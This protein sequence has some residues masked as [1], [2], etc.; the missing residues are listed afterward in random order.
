MEGDETEELQAALDW[1]NEK[2]NT[3]L[4]A[5][6]SKYPNESRYETALRYI[7]ERESTKTKGASGTRAN[8][9]FN[10]E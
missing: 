2:M 1:L 6:E 4:L 3:L 5:V 7:K 10:A 8:T 9:R